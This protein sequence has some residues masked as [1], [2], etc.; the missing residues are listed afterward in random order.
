MST[1]Y[2]IIFLIL[3]LA[4]VAGFY[5][6]Y[7]KAGYKG[8]MALVPFYNLWIWKEITRKPFWWLLFFLFPFINVFMGFLYIIELAKCFNQKK[9]WEQALSVIFP[10]LW[11][12][13]IGFSEKF[14]Y[15]DPLT[16]KKVKKSPGREWFDAII[17]AVV[18]ATIIRTFII[19]AFTIPTSSMEKSLLVGD[20]LFVS[21]IN[22]GPKVP[23]TPLT[24]PFTHHTMFLTENKK[25][26][27]EWIKVPH[28]RF[29]G[30]QKVKR[31]DCVVFNYPDGDT[32][33]LNFPDRSYYALCREHG[34]DR[35]NSDKRTFG[36]I[37]SR[38]VD[39]REN[40][41]KRC[42]AIAGDVFEIRDKYI[43]INGEKQDRLPGEQFQYIVQTNG[44][45]L[46]K[47]IRE[48]L[49]ITDRIPI[50]PNT[51][52]YAMTDYMASEVQ[53][54]PNVILCQQLADTVWDASVFPYS[55]EYPWNRDNFGPITIP[56]TGASVELTLENLPLYERI[57]EVY[58]ANSLN[59]KD[60]KIYIN[61]IETT[62]YTF[63]MDY[64]WMMGD[65]R[66]NSADSRY[67]GFVPDDHVV[68]K[69]LFIWLSLDPNLSLFSKIRWSRLFSSVH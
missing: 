13:Y 47:R 35:V 3:F 31:N 12:P 32:V 62:S 23:N 7:E 48:K 26:Y 60:G 66:H 15:A 61:G 68:G 14:A 17:F 2:F 20:F 34:W 19:E 50:G 24:F 1:L 59:V 56:A 18:A 43:Y 53:N 6:M 57:I 39:K 46:N 16:A 52:I 38:P 41:I 42:V 40:Y 58:E 37:V 36:E 63:K 11:M 10:F 21:K 8:W 44:V 9:I 67:W 55:R 54:Y 33:A 69:A 49:D 29:P 51:W 65:N 64:Y 30:F 22:Y 25:S 5:K 45:E 27:L 28:Y 4:P